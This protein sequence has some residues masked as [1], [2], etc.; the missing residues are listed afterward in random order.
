[1]CYIM[2]RG[3]STYHVNIFDTLVAMSTMIIIF[4][5]TSVLQHREVLSPI[6]VR[7]VSTCNSIEATQVRRYMAQHHIAALVVAVSAIAAFRL[8]L[9]HSPTTI[10]DSPGNG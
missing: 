1:M 6:G 3:W 5:T 8:C 4:A 7:H 10:I 9:W 2:P